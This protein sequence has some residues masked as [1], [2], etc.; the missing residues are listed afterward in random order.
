[1]KFNIPVLLFLFSAVSLLIGVFQF[2]NGE[3]WEPLLSLIYSL[4]F[5][6]G[7]MISKPKKEKGKEMNSKYFN[8]FLLVSA[9]LMPVYL[10]FYPP[11]TNNSA[12]P[13]IK[14]LWKYVIAGFCFYG[15]IALMLFII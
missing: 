2:V 10:I 13:F 5:F 7:G 6:A 4:V 14:T 9:F 15:I 8:T 12:D 1:M 3:V 11:L